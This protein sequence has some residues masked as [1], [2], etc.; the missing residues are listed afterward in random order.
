V[1]IGGD[2]LA[3][4][5]ADVLYG[6]KT[7][8]AGNYEKGSL[9]NYQGSIWRATATVATTDTAPGT[10]ASAGPPVVTAAPW[11]KIPLT[12]GVHNVPTD[13]D[14][15]AT[16]PPSEVYLVL[17]STVAGNKPGLFSYD[18]GTT[19]WV[20]LGGGNAANSMDLTGGSMMTSIGCPIGTIVMWATTTLPAGWLELNGQTINAT[21][22]PELAALF[23]SGHLPDLRGGFPRMWGTGHPLNLTIQSWTT[24]R[25]RNTAFRADSGGDHSH[26]LM[27]SGGTAVYAW[28][29]S[30][31]GIWPGDKNWGDEAP[32]LV[33]N[34]P[35]A[36]VSGH[37]HTISGGDTE[38]A[39]DHFCLGFIIKASDVGVRY[40]AVTP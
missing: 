27:R 21:D 14:L 31:R 11:E 35:T 12:A 33:T 2:L 36:A 13:A 37:T 30:A 6:L 16:A 34:A 20:Q 23:P 38:T 17:N 4:S 32:T 3:R 19:A 7:W 22:Y 26:N 8:V 10:V 29:G 28:D 25:P 1:Q 40:R 18:V 24:G 9:V 5:R 39:P 15:P